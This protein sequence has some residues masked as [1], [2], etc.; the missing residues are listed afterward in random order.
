MCFRKVNDSR[1][2]GRGHTLGLNQEAPLGE[3]R[4]RGD[5][6]PVVEHRPMSQVMV[7][8]PVW[9]VQKAAN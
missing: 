1:T 6:S 8:S 9:G 5:K 2:V 4:E 7:R 3:F